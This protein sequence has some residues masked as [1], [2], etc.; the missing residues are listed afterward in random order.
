[1]AAQF[2]KSRGDHGLPGLP[3]DGAPVIQGGDD[4]EINSSFNMKTFSLYLVSSLAEKGKTQSSRCDYNR[5][6]KI[7]GALKNDNFLCF[8]QNEKN[9]EAYGFFYLGGLSSSAE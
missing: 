4:K 6:G 9:I 2:L 7:I 1:M 3:Y 8:F 5:W